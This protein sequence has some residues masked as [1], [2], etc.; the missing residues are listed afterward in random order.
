[1]R[2]RDFETVQIEAG[3]TGR[4]RQQQEIIG[5]S[6]N[7]GSPLLYPIGF[8]GQGQLH[9]VLHRQGGF[10]RAGAAGSEW[11]INPVQRTPFAGGNGTRFNGWAGCLRSL[12]AWVRRRRPAVSASAGGDCDPDPDDHGGPG[13]DPPVRSGG[14]SRRRLLLFRFPCLG[15]LVR[16][17]IRFRRY[18]GL[19]LLCR[20]RF[21]SVGR[22]SAGNGS[23]ARGE[24]AGGGK[25]RDDGFDIR[26]DKGSAH[27]KP[28]LET[29]YHASPTGSPRLIAVTP[30]IAGVA[31]VQDIGEE[32]LPGRLLEFRRGQVLEVAG[33]VHLRRVVAK[34]THR[35]RAESA[36]ELI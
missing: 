22:D 17:R 14:F 15:R 5:G 11:N 24:E 13:G 28:P 6:Q 30:R 33:H 19:G 27:V 32:R 34:F 1:L 16:V 20:P 7:I 31:V 9:K 35:R 29:S 36:P 8:R 18:A 12:V 3:T 10:P 21:P 2:T 23:K 25:D 4:N 26:P